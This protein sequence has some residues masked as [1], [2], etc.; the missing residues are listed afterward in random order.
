MVNDAVE[1]AKIDR[2]VIA[3]CL[4]KNDDKAWR[5]FYSHFGVPIRGWIR[6]AGIPVEDQ[7][8][9]YQSLMFKI[10]TE[11]VLGK[12]E[13]DSRSPRSYLWRVTFNFCM[14]TYRR[15]PEQL[16]PLPGENV[17]ADEMGLVADIFPPK[18]QDELVTAIKSY[19]TKEK[20]NQVTIDVYCAFL[21]GMSVI[22]VAEQFGLSRATAYRHRANLLEIAKKVLAS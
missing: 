10:F 14:D 5:N 22:K 7:D 15:S 9:V 2:E 20:V 6:R 12:I 19:V 8:E 16:V 21:D 3:A 18:S 11:G 1:I 17:L 13:S 4:T